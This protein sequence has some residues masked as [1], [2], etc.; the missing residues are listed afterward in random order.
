MGLV[1][2]TLPVAV[3]ALLLLGS[4]GMSMPAWL[5]SQELGPRTCPQGDQSC[6]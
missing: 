6:R 4:A 1:M 5:T 3:L 2:K